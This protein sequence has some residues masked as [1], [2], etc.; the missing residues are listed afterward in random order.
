MSTETEAPVSVEDRIGDHLANML[1]GDKPEAEQPAEEVSD[2]QAEDQSDDQP[3]EESSQAN[4]VEEIEVEVEGWKGKIPAKLKAE[5]DKAS[6]YTRKTQEV[7]DQRRVIEAQQRIQQE[8]QAFYQHAQQEIDQLQQ[9][10][11]QLEQYRK[12]DLSQIDG[13]TL[14]RM[15]MAAANL[16]EERAK[17]KESIDGKRGEFKQKVVQAWDEMANNARSAVLKSIP[18]WD[19]VAKSVAEYAI[20]EGFPFEVITGYDKTTRE[21]VGPGVVDPVFARALHKAWK[22]DQLQA[23][24]S[25]TADKTAKAAP[26]LKP[27]AV[28]TRGAEKVA[29][30]NF[31]KAIKNA[32]SE[33]KK[34][35][36][37]GE[38]LAN[39][40]RF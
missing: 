35:E 36:L 30:M 20:S 10:E 40:F 17:L 31:R 7:A 14:S 5:L 2:D 11:A 33:N 24:K 9:I 25:A 6:D 8:Q 18:D 37:I 27:G 38:R 39:K 12:V 32:G 26:V 3:A 15:S 13:E 23:N 22:W 34:A 19:R 4:A 16:R 21:R 29:H 28:D 1:G